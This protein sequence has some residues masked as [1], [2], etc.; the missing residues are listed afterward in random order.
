MLY[1]SDIILLSLHELH[2]KFDYNKLAQILTLHNSFL[3]LLKLISQIITDN[4]TYVNLILTL[5]FLDIHEQVIVARRTTR[6]NEGH[7]FT[8]R[9]WIQPTSPQ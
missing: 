4:P 1:N 5:P 2:N 8:D 3:L 9:K 7:V 6:R